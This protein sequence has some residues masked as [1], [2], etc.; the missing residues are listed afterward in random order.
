MP[1]LFLQAADD[2]STAPAYGWAALVPGLTI[3]RVPGKH[4]DIMDPPNV[5]TLASIVRAHLTMTGSHS[6]RQVP[7]ASNT[8]PPPS[9][10]ASIS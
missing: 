10:R 7:A 1:A 4:M 8:M 2:A 3:E 5:D 9:T 6:S